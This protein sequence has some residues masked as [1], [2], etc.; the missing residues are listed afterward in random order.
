MVT[1][2]DRTGEPSQPGLPPRR[3]ISFVSWG[4][5][6]GRSQEIAAAIGGEAKCFFAPGAARRP[7]V[8]V[9][10]GLAAIGTVAYLLRRRPKVVVVTNPPIFASLIAYGC[11]RVIG[12]SVVLDS[13]PGGFGVQGDRVAARLQVLHR[14]MVRRAAMVLVTD[15]V[16]SERVRSWGGKA[17]VVHEAP[18]AWDV[19]PVGRHQRPQVLVVGRLAADEPVGS[20]VEAARRLP[21]CDF[22]LTGDPA[23]CAASIRGSAPDNVTFIGFLDQVRYRAAVSQADVVLTL[24]TEPTSV[25]RAAYEAVYA[26]RPLVVSDWPLSRELFPY[27]AHA[28]HDPVRLADAISSLLLDYERYAGTVEGARRLQLERWNAQRDALVDELERLD[29]TTGC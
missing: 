14:W 16:W 29:S 25:M 12:A 23:N 11:A 17:T 13:H 18:A 21:E 9:R 10:Y 3:P 6:A 15:E 20:V 7:P 24:T 8:L 28:D 2:L 19:R 4:A 26:S 27:A 22:S 1:L 5:V